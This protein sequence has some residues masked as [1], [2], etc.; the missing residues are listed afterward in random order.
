MMG[1]LIIEKALNEVYQWEMSEMESLPNH[2]FSLRFRRKMKMMLRESNAPKNRTLV[3]N[4]AKVFQRE[5]TFRLAL[6]AVLLMAFLTACAATVRYVYDRFVREEHATYSMMMS[7]E[8]EDAPTE[9]LEKYDIGRDMSGYERIVWDDDAIDRWIEYT[10]GDRYVSICQSL[11]SNY[12]VRL[13]TEN[14]IV[15]EGTVHGNQAICIK[16]DEK[17]ENGYEIIWDDGSYIIEVWGNLSEE[18]MME[19]ANSVCVEKK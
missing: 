12:N 18:E 5:K 17:V 8:D 11:K 13:N 15:T 3:N 10:K 7:I 16:L 4:S 14:A 6:V 9:I 19:I 1:H 2:K